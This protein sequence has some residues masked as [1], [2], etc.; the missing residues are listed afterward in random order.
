MMNFTP[1]YKSALYGGFWVAAFFISFMVAVAVFA[2]APLPA[3]TRESLTRQLEALER[4][5]DAIDKNIQA[6]QAE[7]RTLKNELKLLDSQIRQRE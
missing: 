4:E 3:A 2:Q 5:A 7:A 6:V 1:E